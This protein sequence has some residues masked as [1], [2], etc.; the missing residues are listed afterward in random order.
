MEEK[1]AELRAN[2]SQIMGAEIKLG[3]M[4]TVTTLL[5]QE[6]THNKSTA[7]GFEM[8]LLTAAK[9]IAAWEVIVFCLLLFAEMVTRQPIEPYFSLAPIQLRQKY[10]TREM[11]ILGS[12]E[13]FK[14]I[15]HLMEPHMVGTEASTDEP[16]FVL[17]SAHD[18]TL[19]AIFTALGLHDFGLP[20]RL[21]FA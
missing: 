3:Q 8:E 14:E 17:F 5:K 18:G 19:L 10:A 21:G 11:G 2:L 6:I 4:S 16:R 20:F 13:L 15:L 9:P 12:G 1:T 7:D